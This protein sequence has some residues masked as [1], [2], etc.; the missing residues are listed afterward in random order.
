[1][2]PATS[3][4]PLLGGAA[5]HLFWLAAAYGFLRTLVD[6]AVAAGIAVLF[7]GL[8]GHW[9][10]AFFSG[11]GHSG[12]RAV[13]AT[14]CAGGVVTVVGTGMAVALGE[15]GGT[16]GAVL[17]ATSW[18]LG[19]TVAVRYRDGRQVGWRIGLVIV[20]G[21]PLTIAIALL[22]AAVGV[23]GL[24]ALPL[25]GLLFLAADSLSTRVSPRRMAG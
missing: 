25:L 22:V 19:A 24:V 15:I 12:R 10:A 1:M 6:D 16:E 7:G 14:A 5:A 9:F 21:I 18:L 11:G 13:V 17:W 4:G 20:A 3:F 2:R 23:L 8:A